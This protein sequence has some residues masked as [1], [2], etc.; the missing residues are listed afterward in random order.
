MAGPQF[1]KIKRLNPNA[2]NEEIIDTINEISHIIDQQKILKPDE[3][4]VRARQ[5]RK[6]QS[7]NRKPRL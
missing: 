6:E 5:V 7:R 4:V 2:T 3:M 1:W